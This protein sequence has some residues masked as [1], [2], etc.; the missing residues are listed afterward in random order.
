M[1]E[2]FVSERNCVFCLDTGHLKALSALNSKYK[3]QSKI[4]YNRTN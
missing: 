4:K 1:R 2:K 3:S